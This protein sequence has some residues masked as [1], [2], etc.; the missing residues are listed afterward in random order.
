MRVPILIEP[1]EGGSFRARAGEPFGVSADGQTPTEAAEH[2]TV[3][4]QNR[5]NAGAQLAI[6]DLAN[7][8][9]FVSSSP[10]H[11]EPLPDDDWFFQTMREA[12]AENRQRENE[13]DR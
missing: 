5:L 9:P 13:T 4:L 3:L 6:I 11:L 7:G 8:P 2:L 10:L 12:I 1:G